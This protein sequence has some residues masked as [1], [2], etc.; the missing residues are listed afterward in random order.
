MRLTTPVLHTV[1][2]SAAL[3]AT[4][5]MSA[6]GSGDAGQPAGSDR[7]GAATSSDVSTKTAPSEP[8]VTGTA[9]ATPGRAR[10]ST[11]DQ[12]QR[13]QP[14]PPAC[15]PDNSA[16][17]VVVPPTSDEVYIAE[18][19]LTATSTEGCSIHGFPKVD[20]YSKDGKLLNPQQ[21]HEDENAPLLHVDQNKTA[22]ATLEYGGGFISEGGT[23]P[24][25]TCG[26]EA[27]R[28]TVTATGVGNSTKPWQTTILLRGA[29]R[30]DTKPGGV[31]VCD[32]DSTVSSWTD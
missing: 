12:E 24:G 18:V 8:S 22:T 3:G 28:A 6:C 27:V 11:S 10:P 23:Q 25:V 9:N 26:P 29:S 15:S 13:H 30:S 16:V 17:D 20:L 1:A 5:V 14:D 19:T 32:P 4:L 21:H 2:V 7:A 31:I